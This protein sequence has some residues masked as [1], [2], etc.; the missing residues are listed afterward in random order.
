MFG[1][2]CLNQPRTLK[3]E[4]QTHTYTHVFLPPLCVC[5]C[6]CVC[7]CSPNCLSVPLPLSSLSPSHTQSTQHAHIPLVRFLS[8]TPHSHHA[9]ILAHTHSHTHTLVHRQWTRTCS[10]FLKHACIQLARD[11]CFTC[12]TQLSLTTHDAEA[13]HPE[14]NSPPPAAG[15]HASHSFH[16]T[17]RESLVVVSRRLHFLI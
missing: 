5:V 4:A 17:S 9:Y 14:V 2:T 11:V 8:L 12:L 3:N 6:V 16:K 15:H 13:K 7:V 1:Q 10:H